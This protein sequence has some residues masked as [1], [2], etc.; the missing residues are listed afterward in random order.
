MNQL[1]QAI[2]I[3]NSGGIVIFPTDTA[4]G[5]GCRIDRPEAIQKLFS[6][7]KRP[8][9]QAI[10]LL[11]DSEHMA[12][13][14]WASPLPD[15][16]R[17]MIRLYWPGGLTI[18]YTANA[19]LTPPL[20]SGNG[21]TIGIRMP[22]HPVILEL[23]RRVGVPILGPSANFH[24]SPTPFIFKDLDPELMKLVDF[25]LPGECRAARVTASQNESSQVSTVID[26][27]TEPIKILRQGSVII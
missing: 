12:S 5:I 18:V 20:V 6:I 8:T 27:T 2:Q 11:V 4:F 21:T 24:G 7:R 19:D 9:T 25:V 22:D 23:I 14:Y 1:E 16:V 3:L 17:R 13:R 26:C 15:I 10:T